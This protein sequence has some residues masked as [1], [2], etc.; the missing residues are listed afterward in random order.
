MIDQVTKLNYY[1]FVIFFIY[2]KA[3]KLMD[4]CDDDDDNDNDEMLS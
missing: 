3:S 4:G 1:I 2:M